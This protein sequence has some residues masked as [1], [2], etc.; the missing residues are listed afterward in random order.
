VDEAYIGSSESCDH[1]VSCVTTCVE[2]STDH[3]SLAGLRS[4]LRLQRLGSHRL[5]LRSVRGRA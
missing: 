4:R 2:G 5:R 1:P 3:L